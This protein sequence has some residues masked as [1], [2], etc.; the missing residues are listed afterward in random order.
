MVKVVT[1][2]VIAIALFAA[3]IVSGSLVY[4]RLEGWGNLDS[5]YFTTITIMTVG[6]GDLTPET[7]AGKIFTIGYSIGGIA[8]AIYLLSSIGR[9][10]VEQHVYPMK[11]RINYAIKRFGRFGKALET[12]HLKK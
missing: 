3:L 11:K 4:Q 12:F 10:I 9:W 8:I 5:L 6:Y 2:V 1:H 7:D